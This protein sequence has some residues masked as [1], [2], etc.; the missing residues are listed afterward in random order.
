[1]PKI[2]MRNIRR[3][4]FIDAAINVISQD[5][6]TG[7]SNARVAVLAN[8]SP[9]LL[10]HYFTDKT[11]LLDA[12]LR[13]VLRRCHRISIE[14]LGKHNKPLDRLHILIDTHFREELFTPGMKRLC[15][16]MRHATYQSELLKSTYLAYQA[17]LLS[18]VRREMV[19]LVT[20]R[21]LDAASIGFIALLEGLWV[22]ALNDPVLLTGKDAAALQKQYL[23]MI[24]TRIRVKAGNSLG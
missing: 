20:A 17:R 22:K 15:R 1:M 5:G 11:F 3:Q 6:I 12:I 10:P 14:H 21:N 2:G 16:D 24:T 13:Q 9:S 7:M 18:A 19:Q 8:L 4:Q 23:R